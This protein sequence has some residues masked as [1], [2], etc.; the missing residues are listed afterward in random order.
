M[1]EIRIF[2][3][4]IH[5]MTIQ[6]DIIAN[7]YYLAPNQEITFILEDSCDEQ[8]FWLE[9]FPEN[10]RVLTIPD[11]LNDFIMRDGKKFHCSDYPGDS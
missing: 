5:R 9:E 10:F 4:Q 11:S 6:V 2:N 8:F 7:V 1:A 3:K